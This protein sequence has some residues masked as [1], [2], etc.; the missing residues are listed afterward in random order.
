MFGWRSV[1]TLVW[2]SVVISGWF[3]THA[4]ISARVYS[5]AD[6]APSQ[7]T[8]DITNAAVLARLLG[9][10]PLPQAGPG[11]NPADRFVLSGVIASRVGQGAALIAVDGK[12]AR[13]FTVGAMLSPGYVLVSLAPR[14]AMLAEEVNSP[15]RLTLSLPLQVSA[16]S[17]TALQTSLSNVPSFA[18]PPVGPASG[19]SGVSPLV[20]PNV[21]EQTSP[22]PARADARRQPQQLLGREE[23]RTR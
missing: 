1:T 7:K 15:V 23:Q 18:L 6:A 11:P 4:G 5:T 16:Q 12:P 3:W 21:P 2:A 20:T 17:P 9:A 19:I 13:P 10:S 22:V 8:P 14:E